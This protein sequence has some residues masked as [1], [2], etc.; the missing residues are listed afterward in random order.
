MSWIGRVEQEE[1]GYGSRFSRRSR[2]N[3]IPFQKG[4]V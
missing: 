4:T 1:R 2:N 3:S